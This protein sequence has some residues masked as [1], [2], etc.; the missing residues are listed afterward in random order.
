MKIAYILPSLRNQGP[1]IVVKNIVDY[2]LEWGVEIDVFYFDDFPSA[3]YFNCPVKKISM[4]TCIDFEQYDIVHSHCLRPD[5]YVAKWKKKLNRAKLVST[6]HQDTY[7][8]FR[9][10]YNFIMSYILTKYWCFI[11]S[12]FDAIVSISE[13]LRRTYRGCIKAPIATIYNG[14]V[15]NMDGE[16]DDEIIRSILEKKKEY[17]IL[18][19]YAFVTSRKGLDQI[20]KVLPYLQ[21]Y[22]FII[23]GEGPDIKEL[24]LLSQKLHISDRVIFFS[25]QRNPCNY[26]PYFDV[27]V[28]PSYSEGFGLAMV[29]AALAKRAIVCSDIPSFHEIFGN[30]EACFFTLKDIKSLRK[31]IINAYE[32]R[33]IMGEMAYR[34]VYNH[35]TTQRMAENHLIYYKE[36]LRI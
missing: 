26:L 17:K 31:A 11:Q 21:E 19:T 9:Y 35:F 20:I 18:G 4:K 30:D 8:T 2:L 32:N 34:R 5:I 24:K 10:Q 15:I 7:R 28:M 22:V 6:L 36:L 13:Q 3:M 14:C 33:N 25:Y 1:V 16:G 27:Y 23:I 12:K 29:E